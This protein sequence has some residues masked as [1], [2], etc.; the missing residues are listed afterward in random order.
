MQSRLL[1]L[2]QLSSKLIL[3]NSCEE[4]YDIFASAL[5]KV[6]KFDNFALLIKDKNELKIVKTLGIYKPSIP[7]RLDGEKGVTV[8]CAK[9]KKT[10][11][12]PDVRTDSR[13]IEA[14]PNIRSEVAIPILYGDELIGVIDVE[15]AE[16][17]GFKKEDIQLLETFA[18]MLAAAFKNVEFK[19]RLE[20]SE[21]KYRSIFENAVEGIYRLSKNGK[22]LEA[23]KALEDFF[24]Y[25]LEELKKM[26]LSRLY[27]E[28][29]QRKKFFELLNKQGYVKN[30]EIEYIRKDGKIVIGNEF[31]TK[32]KERGEEYIDGII[33]NI[34]ELKKAQ[35]EADFYNTLLRHD[36]A[37]K[38]QLIIGYLEMLLENDLSKE[39]R[40]L[41]ELA[42]KSAITACKII[43][44]VRKLQVLKEK[45][46]KEE[47]DL[48]YLIRTIVHEYGKDAMEKNIKIEFIPSKKKVKATP[49]LR[50]AISNIVW[51][52]IIHSKASKIRIY[53][54]EDEKW[55]KI[56]IEDNGVGIPDEIKHKIFDMG[57]KGK[58]S[59]GS[60]LGL[61]LTK[62]I[63]ENMGGRL[64]VMDRLENGKP[65]GVVFQISL[66]K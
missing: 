2:Y 52:S 56:N 12:V 13:Y 41:A 55:I 31:A 15:K 1:G 57:Y 18:N 5:Q 40:E 63:I 9:E 34:T 21:R 30:Y 46:K 50:E 65:K 62:K 38:L 4:I 66:P 43:E 64:E 28:P 36:V 3:A 23:N 58:E 54:E 19:K 48:D 32:I 25:S 22:I 16:V 26:D 35:Q 8:A 11:Y 24:G 61:Y 20:E 14:A 42:M 7:L 27:K 44:S 51:N 39:Q 17:D 33:H 59:K 47:I 29:T 6:L 60:G 45:V 53:V 49:F 10:V 37:N